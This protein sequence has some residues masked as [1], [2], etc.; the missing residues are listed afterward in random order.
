MSRKRGPTFSVARG[1]ARVHDN[2]VDSLDGEDASEVLV[3]VRENGHYCSPDQSTVIV[4]LSLHG[5]LQSCKRRE[6]YETA[7]VELDI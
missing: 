5:I 7:Y 1:A 3:D 4:S 6:S 2:L